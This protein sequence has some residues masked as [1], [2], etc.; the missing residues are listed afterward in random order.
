[1]SFASMKGP[2]LRELAAAKAIATSL[3]IND[4]K[5]RWSK[6]ALIDYLQHDILPVTPMP[7]EPPAPTEVP[8]NNAPSTLDAARSYLA[9]G[10]SVIPIGRPTSSQMADP[11]DPDSQSWKKPI[12]PWKEFQSRLATDAELVRWFE[13]GKNNIAIVTGLVSGISIIDLDGQKA[14][15]L[16]QSLGIPAD[17]A[18]VRTGKGLHVYCQYEAGQHNFQRRDDLK[19]I[20][21]RAEGGYVLAPP[22]LHAR[23]NMYEWLSGPGS[24]FPP[25]P[26]WV[27]KPASK[28]TSP[29]MSDSKSKSDSKEGTTIGNRNMG[30]ASEIGRFLRSNAGAS[31]QEVIEYANGWNS[32]NCMPPLGTQEV[33]RTAKSIFETAKKSKDVP[34]EKAEPLPLL[35][36]TEKN[37]PFP[38]E[39]LPP[40][41]QAA[42][43]RVVE[44]IQA[45]L[46]LVCQSFLAAITLAVQPLVDVVIDGRC[47]PVSNNFM[48]LGVSGERK[49]AV[50]RITTGPIKERQKQQ[51]QLFLANKQRFDA[52]HAAWENQRKD[53][54]RESDPGLIESLLNAAGE[55]PKHLLPCHIFSEPS[56]QGIE[57]IFAEGRYSLGLFSDEGG[58]FLGGYAMSKENM[59][60]TITGL[61]KLWDGDPLDRLRGGDGLTIL[62]G[63]RFSVH[64]MLQPVLAGQLFGN[65]ILSGQGFLSRCLCC[66]P[67]STIGMRPYNEADLSSDEAIIAYNCAIKTILDITEPMH[68]QTDMGLAPRPLSL[69]APAK[70]I[71]ID[72]HNHIESAQKQGGDLFP[73]IGFA[74]KAAEHAL[75]SAGGLTAFVNP[76][77][78]EIDAEF[79]MAGISIAQYYLGEALRLFHSTNDDPLLTLAEEC[80]W[81]GMEKTG[82][83]IGLRNLYQSGPNAVRSKEKA[84]RIIQVLEGH[85]RAAKINGGAVV[86]GT[87]NRDAWKLIPL[88]V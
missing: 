68:L 39:K 36:V 56:F 32:A 66:W 50:D 10:W 54:F 77:A 18:R 83:V 6:R 23:G 73:I 48:A 24:N 65:S 1:M 12:I 76:D 15:D 58:K 30:L 55:E 26:E 9:R 69:T 7:S 25:V 62:Y 45:P 64:L 87:R 47:S 49:S 67:E 42:V 37:D 31:Q 27:L 44:V 34:V 74:S 3:S 4:I 78:T 22:S 21:F 72:F 53:A 43:K 79:I 40:V 52:E 85:Y 81:Y 13:S 14:I 84:L 86:S 60:N 51:T 8:S 35:R 41:I 5:N 70:A 16:A 61:S 29:G 46:E 63:R 2:E 19:N 82:G 11:D 75:R 28:N 20:D 71:W 17:A 80:F 33:E 38:V 59:T 88:E 57:R